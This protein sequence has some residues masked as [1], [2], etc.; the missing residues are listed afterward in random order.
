ML[1]FFLAHS[2][3]RNR[4]VIR[5]EFTRVSNFPLNRKAYALRAPAAG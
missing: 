4:L 2:R 3:M 5:C 1:P